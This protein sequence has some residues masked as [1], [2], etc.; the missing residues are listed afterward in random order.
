MSSRRTRGISDQARRDEEARVAA[1]I[2]RDQTYRQ[3]EQDRKAAEI[4][5][6]K[7]LTVNI[8]EAVD[9][10]TEEWLA[11][12]DFRT[13][14]PRLE[15]GTVRTVKA[16]RRVIT[17]M[18]MRL[19]LKG[20]LTDDQARACM[21]YRDRFDTAGVGGR[22]KS[23]HISLTGNVGGG[24]GAGQAPMALHAREAEARGEY[25]AARDALTAFY[26]KF[27]ESVVIHDIPLSRAVRFAKCRNEK[28]LVRFRAV[29]EELVAHC[30]REK[31]SI[32][33]A[34]EDL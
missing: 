1:L 32:E 5:V 30:A 23:S 17:P 2:K 27:F 18:V 22:Y 34:F 19:W 21:W 33:D 4:E 25:R 14:V 28:A 20:S 8:G 9:E 24:G 13:F 16:Y 7:G 11:K 15:D 10:P 12:G 31:V 3:R 26:L 29:A 6:A